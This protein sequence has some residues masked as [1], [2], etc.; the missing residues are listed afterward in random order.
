MNGGNL[1][2]SF[3]S[4]KEGKRNRLLVV[5]AYDLLIAICD[6]MHVLRTK[7]SPARELRDMIVTKRLYM[8]Y[9]GVSLNIGFFD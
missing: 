6:I 2:I 9:K 5:V 7:K 8:Y 3:L 4:G 1:K